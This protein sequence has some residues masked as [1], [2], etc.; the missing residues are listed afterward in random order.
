MTFFAN[1]FAFVE[2]PFVCVQAE[3][4]N[5]DKSAVNYGSRRVILSIGKLKKTNQHQKYNQHQ[6]LHIITVC[7]NIM[8]SISLN[9]NTASSHICQ[10][11]TSSNIELSV[12]TKQWSDA[13]LMK[14]LIWRNNI[15][16]VVDVLVKVCRKMST[17]L[18]I[19]VISCH[20]AGR[21]RRNAYTSFFASSR[22]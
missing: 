22:K 13:G 21:S 14:M 17:G 2:T 15:V 5:Q 18:I 8:I 16:F 9:S 4:F 20:W 7:I 11:W 6:K 10:F 19:Y 12:Y 3:P 1:M